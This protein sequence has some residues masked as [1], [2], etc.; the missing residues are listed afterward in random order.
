LGNPAGQGT[1]NLTLS[2]SYS[3]SDYFLPTAYVSYNF[4][5][6]NFLSGGILLQYQ[7]PARCWKLTTTATYDI[8]VLKPND[9]SLLNGF[10]FNVDLALNISGT[11][12][13]GVTEV[14]NTAV[15]PK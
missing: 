7:S 12:F 14:A 1:D 8:N 5:G 2:G 4:V 6:H 11:G 13:G 10:N 9:N 3:L 15:A